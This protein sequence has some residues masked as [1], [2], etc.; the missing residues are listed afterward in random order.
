MCT[1]SG[2]LQ[3]RPVDKCQRDKLE[4]LLLNKNNRP[5]TS[6]LPSHLGPSLTTQSFPHNSVLSSYPHTAVTPAASRSFEYKKLTI[7]FDVKET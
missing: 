5:H 2:S 4:R 7:C 3:G 6:A 1:K